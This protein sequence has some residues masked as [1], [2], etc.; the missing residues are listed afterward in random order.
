MNLLYKYNK[1]EESLQIDSYTELFLK[2]LSYLFDIV[3][4]THAD[5]ESSLL[6]FLGVLDQAEI[7]GVLD[8]HYLTHLT[9]KLTKDISKIGGGY[10][11]NK[12]LVLD[13]K[14]NSKYYLGCKHSLL[15]L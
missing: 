5:K 6:N 15:L 7:L 10:P 9:A 8:K 13:D 1:K 4:F 14:N 11:Q 3:F 12:I 2:N